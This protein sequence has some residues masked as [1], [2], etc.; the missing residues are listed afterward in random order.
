LAAPVATPEMARGVPTPRAIATPE[1]LVRAP[2]PTHVA[3]ASTAGVPPKQPPA[4]APQPGTSAAPP[5]ARADAA[6]QAAWDAVVRVADDTTRPEAE[7]MAEL[8]RFV[9]DAGASPH[10][11]EASARLARM[12]EEARRRLLAPPDAATL[13]RQRRA[14]YVGGT[15][16]QIAEGSVG[17]VAFPDKERMVLLTGGR[18]TI[19]PF[20]G[21]SGIEYGLT[22][23]MRGIV[24]KK[25]S[26]Y[27]SLTYQDAAGEAQGMVLELSGDEFRPVLTM[28]EARTGQK[29]Q[30]QD[31][32]A[33]RE[34][35][36]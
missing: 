23:R 17:S 13:G 33:A 25:K 6:A 30:Y 24:F 9:A 26:H 35:W 32:K 18:F 4:P 7:R 15:L 27:L 28:L 14:T 5:P 12:E 3:M 36:K 19:V 10:R 22:D 21:V 16:S 8:R 20:R 31:E 34:R 29:I 1:S 11:A 2:A